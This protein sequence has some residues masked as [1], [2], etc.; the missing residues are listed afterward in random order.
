MLS[1]FV[2]NPKVRIST[3]DDDKGTIN[4][5][6]LPGDGRVFYTGKTIEGK[7]RGRGVGVSGKRSDP[8]PE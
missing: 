3:G 4:K 8:G 1:G 7:L 2:G 6:T 5:K